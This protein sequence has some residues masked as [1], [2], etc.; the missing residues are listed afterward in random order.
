MNRRVWAIRLAAAAATLLLIA[1]MVLA[2]RAGAA[3]V[4]HYQ[5][6]TMLEGWNR[7]VDLPAHEDIE[8]AAVRLERA[9][10][11]N[12]D[13]AIYHNELGRLELVRLRAAAEPAQQWRHL[14]SAEAYFRQTTRL[15]PAWPHAW[16]N[17]LI[18]R[19]MRGEVDAQLIGL[20]DKVIETG[21]FEQG[22]QD[23]LAYVAALYWPQLPAPFQEWFIGHLHRFSSKQSRELMLRFERLPEICSRASTGFKEKNGWFCRD[24][25]GG[26]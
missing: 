23:Q 10:A 14:D 18:A 3:Y 22:I 8:A 16:G 6:F 21:P 4:Y 11:L 26:G 19:A 15:S 1:L 12:P 20:I 17:L 24:V 2:W 13:V 7:Y 5:G 9:V 25:K